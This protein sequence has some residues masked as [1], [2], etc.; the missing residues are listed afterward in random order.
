MDEGAVEAAM[1]ETRLA[2]MGS[3]LARYRLLLQQH[4]VARETID[5]LDGRWDMQTATSGDD[6]D[7][8]E[9]DE[10]EESDL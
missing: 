3:H 4:G 2:A 5:E 1:C 8:D 6:D 10:P 9:G 7:D